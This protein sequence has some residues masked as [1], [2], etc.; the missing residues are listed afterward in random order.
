MS[1]PG[2][3]ER[4][5][6]AQRSSAQRGFARARLRLGV[7][8]T[9]LL[10]LAGCAGSPASRFY[11]LAAPVPPE[12]PAA[13]AAA[14]GLPVSVGPIA[15]PALV[16]RP[17][18]V[19]TVGPN[20]VQLDE[21]HRW[22]SPLADAIGLAVVGHLGVLLPSPQVMLLSQSPGGPADTRV[23]IEVQRFDSVPGSHALLDAIFT[24]HG[25]ATGRS[26]TGRTTA[27][28]AVRDGSYET[29]A[30]AHSR[31]VARLA[32]DIAAAIGNVAPPGSSPAR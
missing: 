14:R 17:Q 24:V 6:A 10:L 23:A 30:A 32:A 11:T 7:A 18:I 27:R 21:Y 25:T 19:V 12:S 28:E 29:L 3:P 15:I 16:D 1:A 20:E 13:A 9:V 31:A 26:A 5:R 2:R 4:E 22:A 8:A